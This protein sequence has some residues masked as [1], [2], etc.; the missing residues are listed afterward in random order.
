MTSHTRPY[1]R[2]QAKG[3]TPPNYPQEPQPDVYSMHPV[4]NTYA[5]RREEFIT[6]VLRNP[7]EPNSRVKWYELIRMVGGSQ[8]KEGEIFKSLNAINDRIDCSDFVAHSVLRL[9]YQFAPS[10]QKETP[11]GKGLKLEHPPSQ[12]LLDA[13]KETLL[14]FKYWPDEPGADSCGC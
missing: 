12:E 13:A 4:T 8:A 10:S 11:N 6:H 3:E 5:D 1:Y 14:H 7:T 2:L 9:V